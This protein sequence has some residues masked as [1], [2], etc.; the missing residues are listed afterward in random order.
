M[1]YADNTRAQTLRNV[2]ANARSPGQVDPRRM[3]AAQDPRSATITTTARRAQRC[4]YD[5][6][7]DSTRAPVR[8]RARKSRRTDRVGMRV[9]SSR[10][11]R[12]P[13]LAALD[14]A[15]TYEPARN[16]LRVRATL[17]PELLPVSGD[18]TSSLLSV[19]PTGQYSNKSPQVDGRVFRL[20]G[21]HAK[22]STGRLPEAPAPLTARSGSQPRDE[23]DV[24]AHNA[25]VAV[26]GRLGGVP[27]CGEVPGRSGGGQRSYGFTACAADVPEDPAPRRGGDGRP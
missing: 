16:E 13:R 23:E 14:F 7:R 6:I 27:A 15:A 17:A 3:E 22:A 1:S 25:C 9:A 2:V 19:H 26:P 18:G 10:E 12:I 24:S 20:S 11:A 4:V 5:P 8:R 21:P